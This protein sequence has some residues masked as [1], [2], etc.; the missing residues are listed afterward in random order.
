MNLRHTN[1]PN[2]LLVAHDGDD[3]G[4]LHLGTHPHFAPVGTS[5]SMTARALRELADALDPPVNAAHDPLNVIPKWTPGMY[6]PET[7]V[8]GVMAIL[9]LCKAKGW[10]PEEPK[11]TVVQALRTDAFGTEYHRPGPAQTLG[12]EITPA[13]EW[14][15]KTRPYPYAVLAWMPMPCMVARPGWPFFPDETGAPPPDRS[16]PPPGQ[17]LAEGF[18]ED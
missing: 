16:A 13:G 7:D 15:F 14:A 2:I 10:A 17:G 5:A 4:V 6:P 18:W 8:P 1:D 12:E 11:T 3:I 9:I